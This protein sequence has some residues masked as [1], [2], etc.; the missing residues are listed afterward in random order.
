M[1]S[2]RNLLTRSLIILTSLLLIVLIAIAILGINFY[3]FANTPLLKQPDSKPFTIIVSAGMNIPQL[4][5]I[6]QKHQILSNPFYFN[7]LALYKHA[8]FHLKIGEYLITDSTTPNQLL[9]HVLQGK[10]YFRKI[11]FI[12]GWTFKQMKQA[13][14]K[15]NYLKHTLKNVS[16]ERIMQMIGAKA[17]LSPEGLFFPDTYEYTFGNT[18]ILIL[19][20]SYQHMQTFL[21]K[22]WTKRASHLPYETPYQ[23]LIVASMV[24]RETPLNEEK[25]IIAGII[26]NRWQKGMR[27]QIDP[28]VLYGVGKSYKEVIASK[29]IWDQNAYNT[30]RHKGL[31]P[32]PIS[33]P[34][35]ASILAALHPK[36][37][38]YLYFVAKGDG[39]HQFSVT[40]DDQRVAVN[41]YRST[42]LKTDNNNGISLNNTAIQDNRIYQNLIASFCTPYS[43]LK[44]MCEHAFSPLKILGR[45]D[46]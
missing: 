5:N 4:A 28:T 30:Y 27:L 24:E 45:I 19:K 37:T 10:V 21:S 12:E 23:A 35:A 2:F 29:D 25:P 15:N 26:L 9:N 17:N 13:L 20:T 46:E 36:Q 8:H 41:Q 40:Y 7:L 32:T 43:P 44:I 1:P 22:H 42:V 34:G 18:D 6:L 3:R 14:L 39:G 33:M 11:T 38:D 31:P 16:D